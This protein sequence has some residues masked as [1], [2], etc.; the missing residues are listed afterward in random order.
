MEIREIFKFQKIKTIYMLV[1][2][3]KCTKY[4]TLL[5]NLHGLRVR[6]SLPMGLL[7]YI[8]PKIPM[9]LIL[10][11]NLNIAIFQ[12]MDFIFL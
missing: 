7:R 2:M 3:I 9:M 8:T 1:M 6:H 5:I 10:I 11:N 4:I 12:M